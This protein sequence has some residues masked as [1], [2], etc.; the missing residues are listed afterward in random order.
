VAVN[1]DVTPRERLLIV[2]RSV[3]QGADLLFLEKVH[4][5]AQEKLVAY[6]DGCTRGRS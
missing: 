5:S 1:D 3:L 4:N 6:F 2:G